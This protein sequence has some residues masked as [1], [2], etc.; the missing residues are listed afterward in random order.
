MHDAMRAA[1]PSKTFP[2]YTDVADL[3]AETVALWALRRRQTANGLR[4]V[5]VP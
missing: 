5:L 4:K 2:G 3:A 1:D